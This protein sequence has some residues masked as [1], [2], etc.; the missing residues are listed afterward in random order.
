MQRALVIRKKWW[1]H[2]VV[3]PSRT[4]YYCSYVPVYTV[5]PEFEPVYTVRIRCNYVESYRRWRPRA[6]VFSRKEHL[7]SVLENLL[8]GHFLKLLFQSCTPARNDAEQFLGIWPRRRQVAGTRQASLAIEYPVRNPLP[9]LLNVLERMRTK[10]IN[11]PST[12]IRMGDLFE[13]GIRYSPFV[14]RR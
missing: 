1:V 14:G 9:C 7:V 5:Y 6:K 3:A 4:T 8:V 12:A 10:K 11:Q 13:Y 2:W